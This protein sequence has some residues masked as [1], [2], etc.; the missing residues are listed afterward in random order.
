MAGIKLGLETRVK[1]ST[2]LEVI[3]SMVI[4][5]GVFGIAMMIYTNV[6]RASLS[7]QKL[8]A[9]AVLSEVMKNMDK[10]ELSSDQQS[11][12]DGL[13][14]ERSVKS[15]SENNELLQVDLKAYD[16]NHQLLAELHQLVIKS[17]E[18]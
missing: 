1:A 7:G 9:E 13:S 16:H 15:Y 3:V 10:A 2:V 6:T 8:K 4:I 12:I 14:V 18:Q 11:V 17:D 5:I